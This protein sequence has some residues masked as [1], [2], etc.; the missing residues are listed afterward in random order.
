[1]DNDDG[2]ERRC[3]ADVEKAIPMRDDTRD[4]SKPMQ[5]PSTDQH[6]HDEIQGDTRTEIRIEPGRACDLLGKMHRN[7]GKREQVSNQVY[8]D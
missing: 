1:M 5:E 3:H 8:R 7:K 6:E 2:V 4:Q